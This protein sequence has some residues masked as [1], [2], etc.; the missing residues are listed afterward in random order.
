M[1]EPLVWKL[2]AW[3][4]SRRPVTNWLIRRSEANPYRHLPG[5]ME[6]GWVFNPY[7]GGSGP[8]AYKARIPYLPS[9][10]IHHIV[11]PDW[12]RDKH[13]HPWRART[14][15]LRGWYCEDRL[16]RNPRCLWWGKGDTYELTRYDFHR[17]YAVRSGGTYTLFITFPWEHPEPEQQVWGFLNQS[18]EF[19][20]HSDYH[21]PGPSSRR[22]DNA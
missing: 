2:A 11:A 20:I 16:N 6:R 10:R 22:D 5:Y 15:I 8:D 18:G 1:R 14:I 13:N 3:L 12:G 19:I 4:A 21:E 9:L 17:L 7:P